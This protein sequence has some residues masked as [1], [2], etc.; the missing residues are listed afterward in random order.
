MCTSNLL[1]DLFYK[2]ASALRMVRLERP[3][4]TIPPDLLAGRGI[5]Q[6]KT[7]PFKR[8]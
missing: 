6:A 8:F 4:S 1:R 3:I 5:L 7:T 2:K